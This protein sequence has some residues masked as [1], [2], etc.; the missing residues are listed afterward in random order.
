MEHH[1][2]KRRAM[3]LIVAFVSTLLAAFWEPV[4]YTWRHLLIWL[5]KMITAA[6]IKF[7]LKHK[8]TLFAVQRVALPGLKDIPG[9]VALPIFGTRWI[10]NKYFGRYTITKIHEAYQSMFKEYG[11]VIKEEAFFNY[12]VI[13]TCSAQDIEKLIKFPS[14]F[15]LRPPNGIVSKYRQNT[16]GRY[17]DGGL[18]NEQGKVWHRLRE[19]TTHDMVNTRVIQNL[20]A[21]VN[22]MAIDYIAGINKLRDPDTGRVQDIIE[23]NRKLG[24]ESTC[25]LGLGCRVGFLEDELNPR[26]KRLSQATNCLFEA[27]N[28]ANYNLPLWRYFPN[29]TYKKLAKAEEDLYELA[30]E[31]LEPALQRIEE[32]YEPEAAQTVLIGILKRSDLDDKDKKS[33]IVDFV[34]SGMNTI[35]NTLSLLLYLIAK[36]PDAQT[37]LYEE[38]NNLLEPD[39]P[40]SAKYLNSARYLKA[41]VHEY[42]RI[43][44]TAPQIARI[45]ESEMVLSGYQVPEWSVV[46]CH[47]SA[48]CKNENY[49][50]Q[51]DKFIPERWIASE[52]EA[53]PD[54]KV[55][56]PFLVSPFGFQRRICPGK[57]FTEQ[58]LHIFLATVVRQ[59]EVRCEKDLELEFKFLLAPAGQ[60]TIDFKE[61]I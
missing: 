10:Y 40:I 39:E 31:Y 13:S 49:F 46:L 24:F 54:L 38:I 34:S 29:S 25:L 41:C 36:N 50:H 60:L 12:P 33:S 59:F 45:V 14:K 61:R 6:D 16:P 43:L 26:V 8:Q 28:E 37:K 23:L 22:Y 58:M 27:L 55:Q 20:I 7:A 19:S 32:S 57:K 1:E 21:D 51:A 47:T 48:A 56:Y 3:R 53:N 15:P 18:T 44:P 35:G 52:V 11:Q 42:F 2:E 5:Q 30:S 17:N 4:K 9:P